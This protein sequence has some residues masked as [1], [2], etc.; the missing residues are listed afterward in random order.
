MN[1]ATARWESSPL[2]IWCMPLPFWEGILICRRCH[3]AGWCLDRRDALSRL[4]NRSGQCDHLPARRG[5]GNRGSARSLSSLCPGGQPCARCLRF[6][7]VQRQFHGRQ[8]VLVSEPGGLAKQIQ[9]L[10]GGA[11]A[12]GNHA[13]RHFLRFSPRLRQL[14]LGRQSAQLV[15]P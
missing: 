15:T 7:P 9:Q 6:Y 13:Q 11:R 12:R 14:R 2:T 4:F 1:R 5:E 8:P 10:D 3:G